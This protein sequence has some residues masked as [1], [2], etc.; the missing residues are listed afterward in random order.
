MR[1]VSRLSPGVSAG[2]NGRQPTGQHRLAGTRRADHQH[3]VRSG[4][5]HHERPLGE[6]LPAHVGE[7]DFVR[8]EFGE[9]LFDL[10]DDRFARELSGEDADGFAEGADTKDGDRLDDGGLAGIGGRHEET[11][12]AAL[13]R[14]HRHGQRP[15]H[16]PHGAVE[17]QLA[18]AGERLLRIELE[19]SRGRQH[20]ERDRQIEAPRVLGQ[21]GRGQVNDGA[22]GG[23]IVAEIG[24]RP[25]DAMRALLHRL[26]RQADQ[27]GLG[28]TVGAIDFRFDGQRIDAH[29]GEGVELGEHATNFSGWLRFRYCFSRKE[30]YRVEAS[31]TVR[32]TIFLPRRWM[33]RPSSRNWLSVAFCGWSKLR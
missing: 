30:G 2:Q 28:Q 33:I 23:P 14:R 16:G 17:R 31:R 19:L 18:D 5:R 21:V 9:E 29:E 22:S 13:A 12:D 3:I 32:P 7:I 20:A 10:A 1:V 25:L 11:L 4:G 26:L 15:F 27:H 6:L 24:E 8:A